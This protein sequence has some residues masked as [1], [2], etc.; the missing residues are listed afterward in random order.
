[1]S[2]LVSICSCVFSIL[3]ALRLPRL[4]KRE[5]ILVLFVRLFDLCLFWFVGFLFLLVPGKGCGLWLWHSM[6]FSLAFFTDLQNISKSSNC[7]IKACTWLSSSSVLEGST[8]LRVNEYSSFSSINSHITFVFFETTD[9]ISQ[10]AQ[11]QSLAW[12]ILVMLI[13]SFVL[14]I[15]L[16]HFVAWSGS[17]WLKKLLRLTT[18]FL[19]WIHDKHPG[20]WFQAVS[21]RLGTQGPIVL[22]WCDHIL[23]TIID[24]KV[25][26]CSFQFPSVSALMKSSKI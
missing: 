2:Y 3:L 20:L 16:A 19:I 25:S 18:N 9:R 10:V 4:G 24:V 5:L 14:H 11:N 1:M 17:T 21:V 15:R 26:R 12:S 13:M 8:S 7:C 6:D 22:S 23:P